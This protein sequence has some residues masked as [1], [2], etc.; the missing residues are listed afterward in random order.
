LLAARELGV[1][2]GGT[3]AQTGGTSLKDRDEGWPV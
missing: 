3:Q 2:V 1:D